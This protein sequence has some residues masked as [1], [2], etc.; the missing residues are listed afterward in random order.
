MERLVS[1]GHCVRPWGRG[2]GQC[3]FSPCSDAAHSP[4]GKQTDHCTSVMSL[5]MRATEGIEA[6][7]EK[8]P[9]GL[10]LWSKWVRKGFFEKL[11]SEQR[12]KESERVSLA[13]VKDWSRRRRSRHNCASSK[14]MCFCYSQFFGDNVVPTKK[15][16]VIYR[17]LQWMSVPNQALWFSIYI[18]YNG[19][20]SPLDHAL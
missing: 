16:S 1:S 19:I 8:P 12:S 2:W 10:Y 15:W 3:I 17:M 4:A 7:A 20:D 5:G 11:M 14:E 6:D 18:S 13:A 9:S